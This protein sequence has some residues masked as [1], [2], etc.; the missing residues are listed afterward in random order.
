MRGARVSRQPVLGRRARVS[1]EPSIIEEKDLQT[2]ID[3][4]PGK[5]NAV[6][7]VA[8]IA[9]E[10]QD[11]GARSCTRDRKEPAVEPQAVRCVEHHRLHLTEAE[12]RQGRNRRNREVHEPPLHSPHHQQQRGNDDSGHDDGVAQRVVEEWCH[13]LEPRHVSEVETIP[14]RQRLAAD[15]E[16]VDEI[17]LENEQSSKRMNA[18]P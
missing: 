16:L 12:G 14:L 2:T 9:V 10:D 17:C 13:S 7:A 15:T 1:T 4:R 3:Q 5:G 6:S 18:K 8:G 11:G